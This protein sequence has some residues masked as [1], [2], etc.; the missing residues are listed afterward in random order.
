[1]RWPVERIVFGDF[2]LGFGAEPP[3]A[4]VVEFDFGASSRAGADPGGLAERQVAFGWHPGIGSAELDFDDS[5]KCPEPGV[6]RLAGPKS[7]G[8]EQEK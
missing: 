1:M 7:G 8:Q 3:N 6:A 4:A 2:A 5:L